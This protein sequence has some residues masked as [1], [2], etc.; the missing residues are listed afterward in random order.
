MI[1]TTGANGHYGRAV[2]ERLLAFVP[3]AQVGVSVRDPEK[4]QDLA[5]RGIR[6]RPGD[7][8]DPTSLRHAFEGASQVLIVSVNV[9]GPSAVEQHGNAIAAAKDAGAGRVLYTSQIAA[10]PDSAFAPA[11]DHAATEELLQ[12]SGLPFISLRNGYY[13]ESALWQLG[14]AKKTHHLAL[15]EDGP[16]LW[17]TRSD[18]A[19]A[20]VAV[21]TNPEAFDGI[22]PPL[23]SPNALDFAALAQMAS[24]IVGESVMREIVTDDAFRASLMT[25]G[26]PEAMADGV[27]GSFIASRRGEFA[28]ADPILERLLGRT[29]TPIHS[30]LADF[31]SKPA[32]NDGH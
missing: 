14:S 7:F 13:A 24:E 19:D 22:T 27:L 4:A 16:V 18:L 29:A 1:I 10:S 32:A 26:L 17:T 31:F 9:L 30:I 15:P 12:A 25:S 11:R 6:V 23:A 8:S 20:A 3:A 28:T 21:L 2:A 5:E